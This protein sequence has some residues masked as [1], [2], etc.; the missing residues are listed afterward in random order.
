MKC[1]QLSEVFREKLLSFHETEVDEFCKL[2]KLSKRLQIGGNALFVA[3]QLF[4]YHLCLCPGLKK[5]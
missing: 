2:A 4:I 3:R 5:L 1:S